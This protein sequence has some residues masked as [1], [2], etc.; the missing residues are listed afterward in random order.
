MVMV[1]GACTMIDPRWLVDGTSTDSLYRFLI[2]IEDETKRSA[3][4]AGEP[5]R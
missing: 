1:N 4:R 2:V 3:G 5:N